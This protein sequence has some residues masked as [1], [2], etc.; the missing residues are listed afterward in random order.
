[1]QTEGI[2]VLY[3]GELGEIRHSTFRK[4]RKSFNFN[5]DFSLKYVLSGQ[6]NY[7][8]EKEQ[9]TIDA[10]QALF[11]K[12]IKSFECNIEFPQP[13]S[14]MCID[15]NFDQMAKASKDPLIEREMFFFEV[16]IFPPFY[17]ST[18]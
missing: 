14:G 5:S 4:L 16:F 12:N 11:L 13:T 7:H 2:N 18:S 10:G 1:M 15:L 6:E 3:S 8:F 17:K 9:Y